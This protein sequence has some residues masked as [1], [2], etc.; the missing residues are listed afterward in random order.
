MWIYTRHGFMAVC[1]Y[2]PEKA[3]HS[4]MLGWIDR[5]GD[6]DEQSRRGTHQEAMQE[7][8]ASNG[9]PERPHFLLRA[10]DSGVLEWALMS[11]SRVRKEPIGRRDFWPIFDAGDQADYRWRLLLPPLVFWRVFASLFEDVQYPSLKAQVIA[12]Q[13]HELYSLLESVHDVTLRHYSHR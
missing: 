8:H 11:P 6:V 7:W 4:P 9:N 5:H 10:R 3:E 2:N 12:D 1:S 13:D